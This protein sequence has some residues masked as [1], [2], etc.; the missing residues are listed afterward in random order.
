MLSKN[1]FNKLKLLHKNSLLKYGKK[2]SLNNNLL[3]T[4]TIKSCLI[5]NIAK[6]I[7]K[8][9]NLTFSNNSFIELYHLNKKTSCNKIFNH[10]INKELWFDMP[11]NH[12]DTMNCHVIIFYLY[13]NNNSFNIIYNHD[14]KINCNKLPCV[15]LPKETQYYSFDKIDT[16]D[17]INLI[18][19]KINY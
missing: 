11:L 8:S 15:I 2:Q 4:L 13:K 6:Q 17:I 14:K 3:V 16:K 5:D 1:D 19:Y 7:L 10:F 9:N 18:I 12:Q